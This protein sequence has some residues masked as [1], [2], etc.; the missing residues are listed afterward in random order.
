MSKEIVLLWVLSRNG[1]DLACIKK[2][3]FEKF[4]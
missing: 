1:T 3:K 4:H 2:L